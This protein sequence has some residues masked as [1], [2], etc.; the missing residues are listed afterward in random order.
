MSQYDNLNLESAIDDIKKLGPVR[1]MWEGNMHG[2]KHMQ[3]R[4]AEFTSHRGDNHG[5]NIDKED[6]HKKILSKLSEFD[7]NKVSKRSW[8]K[9]CELKDQLLL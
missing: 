6:L 3:I 5:K 4:K 2:E 7:D 8:S 9:M 1:F